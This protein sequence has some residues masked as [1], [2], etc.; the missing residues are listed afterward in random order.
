MK[1]YMDVQGAIDDIKKGCG[2]VKD[3]AILHSGWVILWFDTLGYSVSS[4][5]PLGCGCS[6]TMNW[7][8][9]RQKF[10][11]KVSELMLKGD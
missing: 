2:I 11:E 5:S 10:V 9:A 3:K 8:I 4:G 1:D 7:D 6:G